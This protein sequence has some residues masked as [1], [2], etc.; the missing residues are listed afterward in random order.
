[1]KYVF[2]LALSLSWLFGEITNAMHPVQPFS[3]L[4]QEMLVAQCDSVVNRNYNRFARMENDLI[5]VETDLQ[6]MELIVK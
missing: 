4:P 2:I 3:I 6:K 1:M 5:F